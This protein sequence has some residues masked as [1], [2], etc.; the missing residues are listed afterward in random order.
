MLTDLGEMVNQEHERYEK[1]FLQ[2]I[3]KLFREEDYEELADIF[4]RS[5]ICSVSK[6]SGK[7]QV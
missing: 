1:Y 7:D 6:L 2:G 4:E 5:K 3:M